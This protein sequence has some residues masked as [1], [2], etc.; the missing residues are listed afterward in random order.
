MQSH[1]PISEHPYHFFTWF[2]LYW[3]RAA[4]PAAI[5]LLLCTPWL[6]QSMGMMTFSVFVQLPL[7][8][9]HQYEE[10]AQFRFK[11]HINTWLAHG[12]AALTDAAI[13]WINVVGVWAGYLLSVYLAAF[14]APELALLPRI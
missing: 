8:M 12:Q 11:T 9:V 7:Y 14:I 3:S 2:Q 13:F 1:P 5:L 10:H 4:L 6:L